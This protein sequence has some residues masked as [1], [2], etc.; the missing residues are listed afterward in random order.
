MGDQLNAKSGGDLNR[1]KA[2]MEPALPHSCDPTSYTT[3]IV[4]AQRAVKQLHSSPLFRDPYVAALAGDE[5]D[6]LLSRWQKVAQA[7][8]VPLEQVRG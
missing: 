5:V 2:F 1:P 7:Q 4:A 6:A 3:R 8:A